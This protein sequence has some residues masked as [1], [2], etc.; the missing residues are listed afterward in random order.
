MLNIVNA[1]CLKMVVFCDVAPCGVLDIDQ[2][3]RGAYCLYHQGDEHYHGAASQKTTIFILVT[4]R[5]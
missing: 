3:F 4:V 1:Y 2:H 5:T